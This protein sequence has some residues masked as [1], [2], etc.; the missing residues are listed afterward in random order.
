[1][2]IG[3]GTNF[4]I[5][6]E[7]FQS[8]FIETLQQ[9]TDFFN[10]NSGGTI[11]LGTLHHKGNYSQQAFYDQVITLGHR[12]VTST[13]A[14]TPVALTQDE[15]V[16]VK[17]NRDFFV[18]QTLDAWKKIA[19]DPTEMSIVVGTQAAKAQM[20][21]Y[22][23]TAVT[24]ADNA[25]GATLTK[26]NSAGTL[27]H[28][29]LVDGLAKFGDAGQQVSAFIMHSKVYY[30][31][32]GQSIADKIT[33]V[34]DQT[35]YTGTAATLG[36]PVIIS[37]IAGLLVSGTPDKYH[38]LALMPGAISINE[39]ESPTVESQLSLGKDNITMQMQ[40]ESA[41]T[42][43][44]KGYAYDITNGGANPIDSVLWTASNWDKVVADNKSTGGAQIV[45]Q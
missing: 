16:K 21:D 39:S 27:N 12:D 44:L 38:T 42:L 31:L 15:V 11:N 19:V 30:D 5:Y 33:N 32:V 10:G 7:Q 41:F 35:I 9:A 4:Q 24:A 40:G 36:R 45:T 22:L 14:K 28:Q 20:V 23:N 2:A 3:I 37:D 18:E 8:G 1:M 6:N 34:A 25:F 17:V 26:D 43:G 13:S 29:G